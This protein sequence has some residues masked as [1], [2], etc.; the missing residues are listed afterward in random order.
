[1]PAG[2][3]RIY[4]GADLIYEPASAFSYI[5]SL[6][7]GTSA[8]AGQVT[9]VASA[10]PHTLGTAVDVVTAST[11][12]AQGVVIT[13]RANSAVSATDSSTLLDIVYD[14]T[15][16]T[17]YTTLV[18]SVPIGWRA[19]GH[20]VPVP[21]PI[22]SGSRVAVQI[23]SVTASKSVD[24]T[25]HLFAGPT[26]TTPDTYGADTANSRGTVLSASGG[27]TSLSTWTNIGSVTSQTYRAFL[28]GVQGGG[29]AAMS[30]DGVRVD[31]GVSSTAIGH[32]FWHAFGT[33]VLFPTSPLLIIPS[34]PVA[35]GSQL[36]ARWAGN[37]ANG[38]DVVVHAYT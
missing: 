35:S 17:S 37:S 12:D 19:L 36:Q 22:P 1:M 30:A 18:S 27:V 21:C 6:A 25:A 38:L 26:I 20:P 32:T 11:A 28:V 15:G 2:A 24:L 33:E 34:T 7:G 4:Y 14:P 8:N 31:L 23:R 13:L 3:D 9:V 16:G 10:T 5:T 29:D